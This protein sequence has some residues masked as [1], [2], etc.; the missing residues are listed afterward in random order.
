MVIGSAGE[1]MRTFQEGEV[2]GLAFSYFLLPMAVLIYY[3]KLWR[4][5]QFNYII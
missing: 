5:Y 4:R 3:L 1:C 2:V